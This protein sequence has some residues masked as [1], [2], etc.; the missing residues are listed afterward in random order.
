M[1]KISSEDECVIGSQV[2]TNLLEVTR[3]S[4]TDGLQIDRFLSG[5]GAKQEEVY[6]PL[7]A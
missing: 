1:F 6:F 3:G 5:S 4:L 2:D 7:E